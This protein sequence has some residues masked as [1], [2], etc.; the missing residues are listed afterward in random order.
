[1]VGK[2]WLNLRVTNG[3]QIVVQALS[4]G[5]AGKINIQANTVEVSGASAN[6]Q[7][8]STI[9]ATSRGTG[10]SGSVN[11]ITNKL[12]A[13]DGGDVSVTTFGSGKG[14]NIN[15][16]ASESIE[17]ISDRINA[18]G[19]NFSRSGLFA[20]TEG[21]GNGGDITINTPQLQVRDGAR[22][23]VSTRSPGEGGKL[24]GKGGNLT[25]NAKI[26]DLSGSSS[27]GRFVS[28]LFALSG[29]QRPT[30]PDPSKATGDGGNV[31]ITTEQL[32]IR[33]GAQVSAA[34]LGQGKGGNINVQANTINVT[35]ASSIS[36]GFS[37]LAAT[38]NQ[39]GDSGN[40]TID[41]GKL[42]VSDGAD[43]SVTAFGTGRSG[44]INIRA[45]DTVELIGVSVIPD[46]AIFSRSGLFAA[47]EGT[48][49]GGSITV[50]S[51]RLIVKDGARVS[52]STRGKG[53]TGIP[54]GRGGNLII[55]AP[56]Q[57]DLTGTRQL[58][59]LRNG[60]I[61]TQD[62][63]SGLFALSGEARP[64][65]SE[66][67]ATGIG[68]NL[69]IN[70]GLLNIRD[71]AQVSVSARGSGTAGNLQAQAN[72]IKLNN[73]SII[74]LTVS[75]NG[76]NI[77]LKVQ[78]SLQLRG[79]SQISTTAGNNGNG[80]NITI[81]ANTLAIVNSSSI[82]A[83]AGRQGGN[84]QITTKGLFALEDAITASSA[85]GTQFSG[86]IKID[87][88]DITPTQG[89]VQDPNFTADNQVGNSCTAVAGKD[90][91]EYTETGRGGMPP[92]P[93]ETLSSEVVRVKQPSSSSTSNHSQ[94][95]TPSPKLP[96]PAS[97]WRFNDLGQVVLTAEVTNLTYPSSWFPRTNCHAN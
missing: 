86:T 36:K 58:Q 18:D 84:V 9:A 50:N 16:N 44:D 1:M 62:F 21:T 25:V 19:S 95:I 81:A 11:I 28:G 72:S 48:K 79:N 89:L 69:E 76:A 55:N 39:V 31:K 10:D 57:I 96:K 49:D 35:G 90:S 32:T 27:D 70:T 63:A 40:I 77:N 6:N 87:T 53:E 23:S 83:D 46:T 67:E 24:G 52:V 30:I 78:D 61:E 17:L 66:N 4:S 85:L 42:Q 74:G 26:I 45:S 3:S 20:A 22:V 15:V 97:G 5:N 65:I 51:P 2:F 56:D 47:T 37:T 14:G 92:T 54:G 68:G 82:R 13:R 91:S 41:T 8:F 43:I 93:T 33:N 80:G 7:E 88:P 34:T 59:L 29:E 12:T 38:S 75:G 60:Q 64:N 94:K 71:G 73:G